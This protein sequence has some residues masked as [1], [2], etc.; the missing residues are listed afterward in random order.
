M[1]GQTGKGSDGLTPG[2]V[3]MRAL[4]N[5]LKQLHKD[6]RGAEGLEKLLIIA[7]IVL[8]LLG[9]LIMFR[10]AIGEWVSKMWNQIASDAGQAVP[11]SG[12]VDVPTP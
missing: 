8:P 12:G 11:G 5:V 9:L 3:H 4:W 1:T 6:E 10:Q 2:R 7:A